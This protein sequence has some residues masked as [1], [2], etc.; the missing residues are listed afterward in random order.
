MALP[1]STDPVALILEPT[2]CHGLVEAIAMSRRSQAD[3]Q[4]VKLVV[5]HNLEEIVA[6]TD[7]RLLSTIVI[8]L[9]DEAIA[10]STGGV[11][12]VSVLG[13]IAEGRK[14][15]EVS[16]AGLTDERKTGALRPP[17]VESFVLGRAPALA[18]ALGGKIAVHCKPGEGSTYVLRFPEMQ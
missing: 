2:L 12:H 5:V 3:G 1:P 9:I 18:A 8:G 13:C 14:A 10:S 4:G 17:D 15:V 7:R 16:I 6:R 11:V